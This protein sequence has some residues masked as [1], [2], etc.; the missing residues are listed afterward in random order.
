M[1]SLIHRG[2]AAAVFAC[3]SFAPALAQVREPVH[4]HVSRAGLDLSRPHDR[5][6][7]DARVRR[8]ATGACLSNSRSLSAGVDEA[9]CRDEMM[10]D[11]ANQVAVLTG[12][13][14]TELAS[15]DR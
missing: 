1:T 11:G 2:V 14:G 3:L 15:I 10:R 6:I 12:G 5:A 8:A 9:R 7:F 4:A 13:R